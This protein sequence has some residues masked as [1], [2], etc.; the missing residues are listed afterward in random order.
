MKRKINGV[1]QRALETTPSWEI[2]VNRVSTAGDGKGSRGPTNE[3]PPRVLL[4]GYNGA[5]NTGSESRLLSIIED[6]R[7]V[8]GPD[9]II[10]IPTLTPVSL[11]RYIE[12]TPTVKIAPIPSIF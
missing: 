11:C 10:T 12:E 4:V 9:A 5:N 6:V 7:A 8:L 1:V 2:G 3:G